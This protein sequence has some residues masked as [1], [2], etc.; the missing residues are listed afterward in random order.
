MCCFVLQ[1]VV[2]QADET[3]TTLYV[4]ETRP[5]KCFVVFIPPL[6]WPLIPFLPL[7]S[8]FPQPQCPLFSSGPLFWSPSFSSL[9]S[10][11]LFF[12][13]SLSNSFFPNFLRSFLSLSLS[14]SSLKVVW[15]WHLPWSEEY[16]PLQP[17]WRAPLPFL[18]SVYHPNSSHTFL[19]KPTTI[20]SHSLEQQPSVCA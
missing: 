5:M 3:P 8:F 1:D 2:A 14:T 15:K 4:S 10:S 19:R 13:L 18:R 12:S 11:S 9:I 16:L 17:G 6:H 7:F 20:R